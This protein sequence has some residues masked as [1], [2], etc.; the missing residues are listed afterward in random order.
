[1]LGQAGFTLL[2]VGIF[3]LVAPPQWDVGLI[4]LV[5][6]IV[7][8]ALGVL[9]GL[10]AWPRGPASQLRRAIAA[11]LEAVASYERAAARHLARRR[12][13]R[14]RDG[15]ARQAREATGRRRGRPDRVPG[16]DGRPGRRA[17]ALGSAR[18][19][20]LAAHGTPARSSRQL[21]PAD[22]HGCAAARGRARDRRVRAGDAVPRRRRRRCAG[23]RGRRRAP[24]PRRRCLADAGAG[25]R[26]IGRRGRRR[27]AARG[28]R[29]AAGLP[30][31]GS[32]ACARSWRA[33]DADVAAGGAVAARASAGPADRT[34]VSRMWLPDGSRNDASIPYG[35]SSGVSTNST[36]R[37]LSSS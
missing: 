34:C 8:A 36:P 32:A 7:G 17:D 3:S 35:R 10:A 6:V 26:R 27:R 13:A 2:I 29:G 23:A 21:P 1:M 24:S 16:G 37:P 14:A 12:G 28:G 19:R 30:G 31:A 4:R 33:L 20:R 11:A 15:L 9:I 22:G 5:D 25:V 18:R